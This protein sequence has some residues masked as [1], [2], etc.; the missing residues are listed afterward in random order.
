MICAKCYGSV[1]S[2]SA[3]ELIETCA[4]NR[5]RADD[6]NSPLWLLSR[7]RQHQHLLDFDEGAIGVAALALRDDM[8]ISN[9]KDASLDSL[10]FIAKPGRRHDDCRVRCLGYFD[11]ILA[12][13]NGLNNDCVE[14]GDVEDVDSLERCSRHAM[15]LNGRRRPDRSSSRSCVRGRQGSNHLNKGLMDRSP[16]HRLFFQSRGAALNRS[17]SSSDDIL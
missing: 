13:A 1:S 15:P 3:D 10:N 4:G 8:D 14:A 12:N 11:L 16:R 7:E 2:D 5:A 17:S 6:G 9:F